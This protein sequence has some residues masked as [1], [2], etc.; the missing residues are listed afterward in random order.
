MGI[1]TP[2]NV[3]GSEIVS[4]DMTFFWGKDGGQG[5]PDGNEKGGW[6]GLELCVCVFLFSAAFDIPPRTNIVNQL[7][8]WHGRSRSALP[9]Y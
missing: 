5:I 4:R 7:E 9:E 3:R 1:S 6:A 2:G 8:I